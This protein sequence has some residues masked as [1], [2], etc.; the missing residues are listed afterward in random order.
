M[1]WDYNNPTRLF[2][3]FMFES[4]GPRRV[5]VFRLPARIYLDPTGQ[6][7]ESQIVTVTRGS[8]FKVL[9]ELPNGMLH[10]Q[11]SRVMTAWIEG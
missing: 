9:G 4:L 3:L 7:S 11:W 10:I 6:E 1:L 5:S 8:L 2:Q